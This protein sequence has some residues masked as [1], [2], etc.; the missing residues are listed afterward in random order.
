MLKMV[1]R[2]T[3]IHMYRVQK[4]SR[5]AISR[6]LGCNRKTVNKI[7]K[8]YEDAMSSSN[9]GENLDEVLTLQPVYDSCN[10]TFRRLSE[11]MI[12][13]IDWCL[14]HNRVQCATGMKKQRKKKCDIYEW[15]REK[16][17]EISYSTVCNYIRM[18]SNI[19]RSDEAFIKQV[20]DPGYGVEFDWGEVKL[21]I[22]D[23][24]TKFYIAVF[25][26]QSSNGRHAYL[27]RHQN[28]LAF[29]ESHRNF[30]MDVKGVP[31][32]M[33]YDN[34]RVAIK[35]FAGL[36]KKPTEALL[37]MSAFYAFDYR[38][39]N[40]RAGWEKG[41]VERSVEY[42]RRK[43]FCSRDHFTSI[44]DAQ[45]YLSAK[46]H[47]MNCHCGSMATLNKKERYKL[48]IDSL[49]KLQGHIGC[50]GLEE[51]SVD[52]WS[53]I[54]CNNVHYSVPDSL[55]GKRVK[56]KIYSEK[57]TVFYIDQKIASHER[58]YLNGDWKISLDHYLE[59]MKRKPGAVGGSVALKQTPEGLR[60][61]F[62][63]NF[64]HN[65]R[66]FVTLL[67]YARDNGYSYKDICTAY[68]ASVNSGAT[69][70]TEDHIKAMLHTVTEN[71]AELQEY[72][73][74][75]QGREIQDRADH[76][77]EVLTRLTNQSCLGTL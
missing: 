15:L 47:D 26:F 69:N 17:Y 2:Q 39:C 75:Q 70:I 24:L 48:D 71:T 11:D 9:P 16:G 60:N 77:L 61:I 3:I 34:M 19:D 44:E 52:K 18:K 32:M 33:I 72:H 27:F 14:E 64:K 41:H 20:Y 40:I 51:H 67:L 35:E 45:S 54:T 74:D 66:G 38:F 65:A 13:E 46:C 1:D 10:R 22:D 56:V 4:M 5:R 28:T 21:Y 7:I 58:S 37:R 59:T 6:E 30:F 43:T 55:V 8:E 73:E 42:V 29:M 12:K 63:N 23:V 31:A 62:R 49:Q 53:T 25:T 76:T 57:I 68:D 36:E 50:F